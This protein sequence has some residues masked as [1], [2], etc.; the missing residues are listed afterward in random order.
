[1]TEEMADM[2]KEKMAT[3]ANN[4][5]GMAFDGMEWNGMECV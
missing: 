4:N 5:D 2:V 3:P 1:M